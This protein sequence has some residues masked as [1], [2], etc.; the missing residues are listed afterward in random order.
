M[1]A[2]MVAVERLVKLYRT[3]SMYSW[4]TAVCVRGG[5]RDVWWKV[6]VIDVCRCSFN[7]PVIERRSERI[8]RICGDVVR[9][10]F[11]ILLK[12]S[13]NAVDTYIFIDSHKM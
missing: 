8:P 9:H 13:C 2:E 10:G 5:H 1:L 7:S 11:N 12:M 3:L 4:D 6:R